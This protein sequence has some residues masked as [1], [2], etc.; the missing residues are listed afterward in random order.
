MKQNKKL[1]VA[2]MA[3]LTLFTGFGLTGCE[4]EPDKYEVTG[5]SPTIEYIRLSD[6]TKKDSMLTGAYMGTNICLVGH[7]LTSI[8]K[9]YFNDQEAILNTSF[10]TDNTLLVDVPKTISD[11]PTNKI[12]MVNSAGDTVTYD[13]KV[14]VPTPLVSSLN[15][16]FAHDGDT[17]TLSGDYLL[18]YA[19]FPL[20]IT[21]PGNVNV[22]K[23]ISY[24]KTACTFVVPEGAQKG[25][26]TVE[27]MYG[28]SR[29]N[30]YFRD[31]RCI[32]F[33]FDDDG[34]AALASGHGWRG[35]NIRNDVSGVKPLDGKYLYLGGGKFAGGDPLSDAWLEDNYCMNYWPEPSAGYPELNTLF[36]Y[37]DLSK[38]Q[39][40]FEVW[41]PDA[42]SACSLQLIFSGNSD[43]TQATGNNSYYTND[44]LPRGLWTPWYGTEKS[45]Y[46]TSGWV[47]VSVPLSN[48]IYTRAGVKS[49][50][51]LSLERMT[52]FTFFL[53]AGPYEGTTCSPTLC[54]DNVRIAPIE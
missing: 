25:Y 15:N 27:S 13:F 50:K 52:G 43:V 18:N 5:G 19:K 30:F 46:K 44:N 37:T 23:F 28:K 29:S 54:I 10:M 3:M 48:F 17:V 16:E 34:D 41:V 49:S 21:F 4:D 31:D 6:V 33:D 11:N 20:T 38:M 12:Y 51:T 35:G 45:T 9:M 8:K 2:A 1:L 53:Y 47:T 22:T 26:V 42:W 7:N 36:K 24:S 14:L 39:M 40:K 32:L